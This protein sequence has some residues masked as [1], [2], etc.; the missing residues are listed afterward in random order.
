MEILEDIEELKG[1][2]LGGAL[3]SSPR[4]SALILRFDLGGGGPIF[5]ERAFVAAPDISESVPG[6]GIRLRGLAC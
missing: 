4:P 5:D 3:G 6:G 1:R 2:E